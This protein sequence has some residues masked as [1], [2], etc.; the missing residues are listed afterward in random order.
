[1]PFRFSTPDKTASEF[2]PIACAGPVSLPQ[3]ARSLLKGYEDVRRRVEIIG[4]RGGARC[5]KGV[6]EVKEIV[7]FNLR[8]GCGAW[9]ELL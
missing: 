4:E 7:L 9:T 3:R 2:F 6:Q 8:R 5:R 1:M